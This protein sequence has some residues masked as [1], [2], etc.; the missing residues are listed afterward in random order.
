MGTMESNVDKAV[1]KFES[2][3]EALG[4]KL[5]ELVGKV[6]AASREAKGDAKQRIEEMKEK[7]AAAR[8][9]LD[10]ARRAGG[11]RWDN[12]KAGVESSW[13]ELERAFHHLAP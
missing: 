4:A 2:E 7:L 3:T 6:E 8:A 10:E 9:K 5:K 11:D 1:S 13:K 12:F